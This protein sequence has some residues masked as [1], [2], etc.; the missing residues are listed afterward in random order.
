MG[1]RHTHVNEGGQ[2]EFADAPDGQ[3]NGTLRLEHHALQVPLLGQPE[4]LPVAAV[5]QVRQRIGL[6]ASMSA[7]ALDVFGTGTLAPSRP[8]Y[9]WRTVRARARAR[10]R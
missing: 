7:R 3:E 10:V 1:G 5:D 6:S 8:R 2:I 4:S 9:N